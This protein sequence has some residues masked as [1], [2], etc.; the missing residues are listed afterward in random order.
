MVLNKAN[1][2]DLEAVEYEL[3]EGH[4]W[5]LWVLIVAVPVADA[6]REDDITDVLEK[7]FSV[8][9]DRF[10]EHV[11]I[12]LRQGQRYSRGDGGEQGL[13]RRTHLARRSRR[14]YAR[15]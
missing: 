3:Y 13:V 7:T 10:G 14:S 1:L 5:M 4:T 15:S 9:E 6:S 8:A 11:V 12:E 2:R